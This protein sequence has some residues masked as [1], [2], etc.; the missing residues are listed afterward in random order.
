MPLDTTTVLALA[1]ACAPDVAPTTLLAVAQVESGLDPLA[2]GINGP[3]GGARRARSAGEAVRT[4]QRLLSTGAD[5][6]L[7]LAQIN[8]RNLSPLGLSLTDAFEPCANLGA[9]ARLLSEGYRRARSTSV[10]AQARLRVALSYYNTGRPER[11]FANG[12]VTRVAVA[13]GVAGA[14][15]EP[16]PHRPR[17]P[18][19]PA[20]AWMVFHGAEGPRPGFVLSFQP[21]ARP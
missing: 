20:A 19:P 16:P 7:G 2:I 18:A 10:S 11:G 1:A 12:Y 15:A 21:G 3:A 6:D 5:I 4:A 14:R 8:A 9:A 13:A 17:L